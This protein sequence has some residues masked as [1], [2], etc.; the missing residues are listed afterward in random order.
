SFFQI[1]LCFYKSSASMGQVSS[2]KEEKAN[3]FRNAKLKVIS[4]LGVCRARL[5]TR[6]HSFWME[7]LHFSFCL[8]WF[9]FIFVLE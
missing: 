5:R 2:P 3:I 8:G 6:V 9:A 7:Y 4:S 1:L